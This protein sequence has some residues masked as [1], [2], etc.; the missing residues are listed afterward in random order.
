[1]SD[2]HQSPFG[3]GYNSQQATGT[4]ILDDPERAVGR[5]GDIAD[6][7]AHVPA[8]GLVRLPVSAQDKARTGQ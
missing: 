8:I 7:R 1:M 5:D 2:L 3:L 6:A 4:A